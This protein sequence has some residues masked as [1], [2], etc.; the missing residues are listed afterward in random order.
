MTALL[1]QA[2]ALLRPREAD[3][4]SLAL[5]ARTLVAIL[6]LFGLTYGAMMGLFCGFDESPRPLQALYSATR[7]PLLLLL[8]FAL[9]LPSFYVLNTLAGLAPDFPAVLRALLATQAGLTFVLA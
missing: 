9:A 6:I 2:D 7:V 5:R 8:T 3:Q 1:H 4:T